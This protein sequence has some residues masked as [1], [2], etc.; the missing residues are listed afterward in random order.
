[1]SDFGDCCY[2]ANTDYLHLL[3]TDQGGCNCGASYKPWPWPATCFAL[4]VMLGAP[5]SR[6]HYTK[7]GHFGQFV[8]LTEPVRSQ[9]Q[10]R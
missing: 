2:E 9:Y 3:G 7:F 4:C 5:D 6:W 1:M 8:H 10:H